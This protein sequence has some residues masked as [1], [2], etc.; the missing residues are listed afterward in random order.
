MPCALWVDSDG[1]YDHYQKLLRAE[2]GKGKMKREDQ[3]KLD[4]Y[5]SWTWASFD[6]PIGEPVW[7]MVSQDL[8]MELDEMN[9]RWGAEEQSRLM[10][11]NVDTANE[12]WAA[13]CKVLTWEIVNRNPRSEEERF[14]ADNILQKVR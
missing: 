11:G 14:I 7:T 12:Y 4:Q 6:D 10:F 3:E 9:D 1:K 13:V 8:L 5:Q 2:H